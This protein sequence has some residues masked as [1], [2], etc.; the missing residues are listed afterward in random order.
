MTLEQRVAALEAQLEELRH[1]IEIRTSGPGILQA[2][3]VDRLANPTKV[4]SD[5]R[6]VTMTMTST[7]DPAMPV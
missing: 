6:P 2:L 5:S 1:I 7:F 3:Y 4:E